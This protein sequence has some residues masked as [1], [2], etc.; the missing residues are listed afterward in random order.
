[1]ATPTFISFSDPTY[2]PQIDSCLDHNF[3]IGTTP[4]SN[5]QLAAKLRASWIILIAR[6]LSSDVVTFESQLD[7][8][9]DALEPLSPLSENLAKGRKI[10]DLL[11][12][13]ENQWRI[14]IDGLSKAN[15]STG[16]GLLSNNNQGGSVPR[17]I[18]RVITDQIE[19][20]QDVAHH[21]LAFVLSA[22]VRENYISLKAIFDG[23]VAAFSQISR[24]LKQYAHI[25]QQ[26][27]CSDLKTLDDV[28]IISS[29]DIEEI[30]EWNRSPPTAIDS[31]V[32]WIIER[33]AMRSPTSP[34]VCAWDG[35]LTYEELEA[36]ATHMAHNLIRN[37]Y[38]K[39]GQIVPVFSE[40]SK[41]VVV[42]VLAILKAGSAF[43]L[44]D[45]AQPLPRIK[46]ILHQTQAS[47]LLIHGNVVTQDIDVHV[48]P[49]EALRKE[50][51]SPELVLPSI[52][53]PADLFCVVFSSGSTGEPK[54][55]LLEHRS[56]A[57][58]ATT[59]IVPCGMDQST[60]TYA[61]SSY[62]FDGCILDIFFTLVAGGCIC[63]PSD[64]EILEDPARSIRALEANWL[65]APESFMRA[66]KPQEI[67]C[68]KTLCL[69]GEPLRVENIR[70]W[71]SHLTL[72][73]G[74][75]PSE[76]TPLTFVTP[77]LNT[78][79]DP[80]NIGTV[81]AGARCWIVDIED[82]SR[83]APIG[84]IGELCIEGPMLGRG[85]LNRPG[86]TA[87]T[88][89]SCK[90]FSASSESLYQKIRLYKTGDL[91]RYNKDGT[92]RF[93]GRKDTMVKFH[94]LKVELAEV[95]AQARKYLASHATRHDVEAIAEIIVPAD[96]KSNR[97]LAV[98]LVVGYGYD[99][100]L[101]GEDSSAKDEFVT[102]VQDL[103]ASLAT[104]MPAYMIPSVFIPL[105]RLQL[106]ATAKLDRKYLKAIAAGLTTAQLVSFASPR[107]RH[108]V[109]TEIEKQLRQLWSSVL[110]IPENNIGSDDNFFILGGDSL[111]AIQLVEAARGMS[112]QLRYRAIF[113]YPIL[114]EVAAT[115]LR[116]ESHS[117]YEIMPFELIDTSVDLSKLKSE[118][119]ETLH[120]ALGEL[121]DAYPCTPLQE[122][123]IA[124]S[125][126]NAEAYVYQTTYSIP[127]AVDAKRFL[128]SWEMFVNKNQILRTSIVHTE[129]AGSLQ[130]VRRTIPECFK[131]DSLKQY[132]DL[133]RAK[134]MGSGEPLFR[135]ALIDEVPRQRFFV[136][137]AHHSGYDG[138]SMELIVRGVEDI[139]CGLAGREAIG[140]N[141]FIKYIQTTSSETSKDFWAAYLKSSPQSFPH[142]PSK[143]FRPL[144]NSF[145][146]HNFS[147]AGSHESK[148]TLATS[149][150][151]AWAL[152][153]AVY[154]N[155]D[156]VVFGI[157]SNGRAID[158]PGISKI[159]GPTLATV[160]A[161]VKFDRNQSLGSFLEEIRTQNIT[162]L[163]HVQF[164]LQNIAR[165]NK[166]AGRACQFQSLLVFQT[167]FESGMDKDILGLRNPISSSAESLTYLLNMDVSLVGASGVNFRIDFDSRVFTRPEILRIAHQFQHVLQQV[168]SCEPAAALRDIE[169]ISPQDQI[170]LNLR[171]PSYPQTVYRCI[172][173]LFR[174]QVRER[175]NFRAVH[176]WDGHFSYSELSH[177][178]SCLAQHLMQAGIHEEMIVPLVFDKSRWALVAMLGIMMAGAAFV[179]L[180]PKQSHV[181][182]FKQIEHVQAKLILCSPQY[183][184]KLTSGNSRVITVDELLLGTLE[185][186]EIN[187]NTH[188]TPGNA[189]YCIF[190]SG[191]TGSPKCSITEHQAFCTGA[192][193]RGS[194]IR[195]SERSK[196]LQFSAYSFDTSLEDILTT[197]IFG[198]CVCTPSEEARYN[199]GELVAFMN[200]SG[201][202]SAELTPSFANLITPDM[203]PSLEV[204]LLGG[205]AMAKKQLTIWS[206]S[207]ELINSYGPSEASVTSIVSRKMS[208]ESDPG[209]IGYPQGCLAW[210]TDPTD[211]HRLT[212]YG[213]VGELLLEGPI[214][215][216]GYLHDQ[217]LTEQCF[218]FD[219]KWT[220]TS[221]SH[222]Q[223][224][225]RF[226]R[227]GD[228]VKY[229]ED[230][231][232]SFV[233]RYDNQVK[234]YGQRIE[235]SEVEHHIAQCLPDYM[236][237]TVE[238]G[239]NKLFGEESRLIGF[240]SEKSG[241]V[242]EVQLDSW[243]STDFQDAPRPHR[244]LIQDLRRKL[245][246]LLPSYMVP[247]FFIALPMLPLSTAG[248][249][250]RKTLRTIVNQLRASDLLELDVEGRDQIPSTAKEKMLASLWVSVL[251]I[252]APHKNQDFFLL[253]GDSFGAIKLVGAVHKQGCSISVSDI[254]EH[255]IL[256]E[257][258]A[259]MKLQVPQ[260]ADI[261][262][263][264]LLSSEVGEIL[265]EAAEKCNTITQEIE[266]IYPC[267]PLQAG[268]MV[269]SLT[270]RGA[271]RA[272]IVLN[273]PESLDVEKLKWAWQRLIAKH[274]ILRTRIVQTHHLDKLQV[275][276]KNEDPWTDSGDSEPFLR[277][278]EGV[279]M[280]FGD[281]L[282]RY[283]ICQ[284]GSSNQL[285][286][287][288]SIHHC[289]YDGWSLSQI[290]ED[291]EGIYTGESV[292]NGPTFNTF[293]QHLINIDSQSMDKYWYDHLVGF[294]NQ[295]FPVLP[296]VTYQP[297][298]EATLRRS[299][300]VRPP[301]YLL[302]AIVR[303][304]WALLVSKQ[305]EDPDVVFGCVT[306]GR[307]AP[308][309]DIDNIVG[310]TIATIPFR[311]RVDE[312]HLI[313]D[314]VG[315]IQ[316]R[317]QAH[318]L[319]EHIGLHRIGNLSNEA[320]LACSFQSLVTV[321]PSASRSTK[322]SMF[323]FQD[324][325]DQPDFLTYAI[326]LEIIPH[327]NH[328]EA[329]VQYD[330]KIIQPVQMNRLL[331]QFEHI[332][333][334][335]V[336]QHD[337]S[338]AR[339]EDIELI[340]PEDTAEVH[341][342]NS[343]IPDTVDEC[344]HTLIKQRAE[345]Y[346]DRKAVESWDGELT[347]GEL[348]FYASRLAD[349]LT[350]LGVKAEVFVPLC[351]EKS[352]WYI[353]SVLAIL[354]AGGAFVP[355][356]PAH[357][358]SRLQD[359]IEEV[360]AVVI[361]TSTGK[362]SI[363][364]GRLQE[365]ILVVNQG[366][367][368]K[369]PQQERRRQANVSG[370]NVVYAI[371]TSGST[372][373]PKGVLIEHSSCSTNALEC[374]KAFHITEN[375]RVL[376]FASYSFDVSIQEM[377]MT[378]LV[379]GCM[380]ICSDED[381]LNN[382]SRVIR[383]RRITWISLTPSFARTLF[384]ENFPKLETIVLAG[385]GLRKDDVVHWAPKLRLIN[386]YG[387][388]ECSVTNALNVGVSADT[389]P[390][391]IGHP[392]GGA[393]WLV[394]VNNHH[395]LAPIG[396]LAELVIEGPCL[397]RGYLKRPA[398]TASSFIENPSWLSFRKKSQTRVYKTGDLV[399]YTAQGTIQYIGRKDGQVKMNGQRLELGEIEHKMH[400]E[401]TSDAEVLVEL[402]KPT[403]ELR[404][405]FLAAFITVPLDN[406]NAFENGIIN[407]SHEAKDFISKIITNLPTKLSQSLPSY[408][409]PSVYIPIRKIPTSVA[410][411]QDRGFLRQLVSSM[412]QV[413]I[414]SFMQ[415]NV[416]KRP[417]STPTE[418]LLH[419]LWAQALKLPTESIGLDDSFFRLGGD[420][421]SAIS[422]VSLAR[423]AK[424]HLTI[425]DI[426][427][428]PLLSKQ[429][430]HV[431][432]K[433]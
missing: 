362:S 98:F 68:L 349:H 203:A 34:A 41:W 36:S 408:M 340:S 410:G 350:S 415:S 204:L 311:V 90:P 403:K 81:V 425:K 361:L 381:R 190:T 288:I 97:M 141:H 94:G 231:S 206:E 291:L 47:I 183:H 364:S 369:L 326:N 73:S 122:G 249:V 433:S 127:D 239:M 9:N 262:P 27:V 251:K 238:F 162:C 165:V 388:T 48:L 69:A 115:I 106:G 179:P 401:L 372:G 302:T 4:N 12:S 315:E 303:A 295:S 212:P 138:W 78:S 405:A 132:C 140:F 360:E 120:I 101:S 44:I 110:K 195:R 366:F 272:R 130:V 318:A 390:S 253:G 134:S 319:W 20:I 2:Q 286:M 429:A 400:Q 28:S 409:I 177:H 412:S 407:T 61:F 215:A 19:A 314:Y 31:C 151:A 230:G 25:T 155:Q 201:T 121:E 169:L 417:P 218:V 18:F 72:I 185:F 357:P 200:E 172:H 247:S 380:C 257:M 348:D 256:S 421:V 299:L 202:N 265:S 420:S 180:D 359:I 322:P 292:P 217:E 363:F 370:K 397:G 147:L 152:V 426:F 365:K 168:V 49:L 71:T 261:A 422:L 80:T 148:N 244:S 384:N 276:L 45:A 100:L 419:G 378:L 242:S 228:L 347:Y 307:T 193:A 406:G 280:G 236:K 1:M 209:T 175:P 32:H 342:W 35:N 23:K 211:Y 374:A 332:F 343:Y 267:T 330:P 88:F 389:D 166:D 22:T 284:N 43:V 144:A 331:G 109:S 386:G 6:Y 254:F 402:I 17:V 198:G 107:G 413:E 87:D 125:S 53:T 373:H 142:L 275:V 241:H 158:I 104:I 161:R 341:D 173:D 112:L 55:S 3:S 308:I 216:R 278:L 129:D 375:S 387:V 416:Q 283:A 70:K 317:A 42:A 118:L 187:Y 96:E 191:T 376:N 170:D 226:Y 358:L 344:I 171:A 30:L 93:V 33:Q 50:D 355:L 353:V 399:R 337:S 352:I 66:F 294:S 293:I 153:V 220:L 234:S 214:L 40:K 329:H 85:Y 164:G 192:I 188:V 210:I 176:S 268:L 356:D 377:F 16:L 313:R 321:Q 289:L 379:G 270:H 10:S 95:E 428:N 24:V 430:I 250:D 207:L 58:G 86:L 136:L 199:I 59:A 8:R 396:S 123:L 328:L 296:S 29:S 277:R 222:T 167:P 13:T 271:Y 160:P 56:F 354:K 197:L 320:R 301:G 163:P 37:N 316:R 154:S 83:L 105:E 287:I 414:Q 312:K 111:K 281:K 258:A 137:T 432:Q 14:A 327:D 427:K 114:S 119:C 368:E 383:D 235:L 248:K 398:V 305:S 423:R 102:L 65:T 126:E 225:R 76:C 324:Q 221:D 157:V 208:P 273:L 229:K 252:P 11:N 345:S 174:S 346:A 279:E 38:V 46:S 103:R 336:R 431:R 394:D 15:C 89:V 82:H 113:D 219:P 184:Q 255:P 246:G 196:V 181:R 351:F 395:R 300:Y 338:I 411:K 382:I 79:S 260:T 186:K 133:D 237:T 135:W 418:I 159:V 62:S 424:L 333:S 124:L 77:P 75:G 282:L 99:V 189:A 182:L 266:D 393:C 243:F 57:T 178:A 339:V 304:A 297:S 84:T 39:P 323:I 21:N 335:L 310:P 309:P 232:L 74:Y 233:G 298:A 213:A 269:L 117:S 60:R 5:T 392:V 240:L 91:V 306:S 108:L 146:T 274:A 227:T 391:D 26:L 245:P 131:S 139:Y 7:D 156:D 143:G 63:I 52:S 116:V 371:Y 194:A 325:Q 223:C 54:G 145:M 334:Q 290:F 404:Q 92:F 264:S 224:R 263:F 259:A 285:Q 51:P 64:S 367:I 385:E 205:E 128:E 67:A 149:V 150:Y